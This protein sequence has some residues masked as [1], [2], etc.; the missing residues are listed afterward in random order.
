[1]AHPIWK[2]Y[3]ATLGTGDYADY[4]V[5]LGTTQIFSGRAYK[6]PGAASIKA[7]INDIVAPYLAHITPDF[8]GGYITEI[9][10]IYAVVKVGATTK[11][12][13]TLIGDWSYEDGFN[14]DTEGLSFPIDGRLDLRQHLLFSDQ[15]YD[16]GADPDLDI[17][18]DYGVP[19][20][21][22][23]NDFN[24]DFLRQARYATDT[25]YTDYVVTGPRVWCVD[26]L[27]MVYADA[28]RI[29]I[30]G[31]TWDV[32]CS[33]S[34]YCLHY[35]NA[36]GGWDS[37]LV[38]GNAVKTDGIKHYER[39]VE[40]DNSSKLARGRDNYINELTQSFTLYTGPIFAQ[41]ASRMHHLL[42]S[43]CVYLEHLDTGVIE[44]IV[45]TGK[46]CVHKTYRSNGYKVIEYQIEAELAQDRIR[47]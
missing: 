13:R 34:D 12:S 31:N 42:N 47:R 40:Y 29:T 46:N 10:T 36:Y 15:G 41:G 24:M 3:Y 14:M 20:P 1:M 16:N 26:F 28:K 4:A 18:I 38:N 25:I 5:L 11:D 35:V 17:T 6:K 27:S 39:A 2:D 30:R 8:I 43:P 45:L 32:V 23:N 37:L 7:R 33:G 9:A 22:F 21:D 19:Y 44:P